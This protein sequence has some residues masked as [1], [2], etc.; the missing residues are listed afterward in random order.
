MGNLGYP[1]TPTHPGEILK[2][3]IEYRGISQKELARQIGVS[4]TMFNEIL[5]AKR[6][7]TASIAL[8]F[9][10]SLGIEAEMLVN[11]QARYNMQLAR[12]DKKLLSRFEEIRK[13]TAIL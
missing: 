4:Y 11:M 12:K 6:P 1:F 9:E 7:V 3:E 2:E 8:M 13:A 5:N 10:A